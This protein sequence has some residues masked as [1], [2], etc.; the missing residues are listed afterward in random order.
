MKV[1]PSRSNTERS[2]ATYRFNWFDWFCLCY[3]PAWLILFNRH[4]RH[5]RPDPDGWNWL[6]FFLFLIPG[7]FYLAVALR[8]LRLGGRSPRTSEAEPDP[9]YQQAFQQEILAPIVQH[10][11][12]GELHG[13][14]NLPSTDPV[15][16]A[17]NHAGMC[18]PWDFLSLGFLLNQQRGWFV[19]PLA[20]PV[21][22]DH[23]WLVWWLP[24]G[25]AQVLGGVRAD[26]HSFELAMAQ[27][28]ILLYAPEGWRGLAKG[29][30]QRYQLD[31]FDPSFV[32]LSLR[33][34]TPVLPVLCLGNE[35]L[36]PF[37]VNVRWLANWLNMPMFPISPLLFVFLLFPSMGIWVV[38]SQLRYYIQ[39]LWQGWEV[40]RD[41]V[42]DEPDKVNRNQTYQM[43][44]TLRSSMQAT[45]IYLRSAIKFRQ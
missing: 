1:T 6:E 9:T 32:R 18:F 36:H 26:R 4:W 41:S 14:E 42:A 30:S 44:E 34:K 11:F 22:F 29:W 3:P 38:R 16:V 25:W 2:S 5:Y 10:Y 23:P 15:I 35:Y 43:A 13:L 45:L 39:P 21:F 40:D 19:Q 31:T 7:G 12:R 37:T 27:K 17:M 33:H 24:S 28:A 20:H 8:W